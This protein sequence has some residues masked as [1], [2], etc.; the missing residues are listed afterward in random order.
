MK[1]NIKSPFLVFQDFISPLH[2]EDIIDDLDITIPNEDVDG[3]PLKMVMHHDR[4]EKEIYT[5]F[6][7]V[8]PTIEKHYNVNHRATTEI[9][10]EWYPQGYKQSNPICENSTLITRGNKRGWARVRDR[11]LT[12]ILFLTEYCD[13]PDFDS[14]YEVF[15][16][17]VEFVTWG[18]GF[19]AERGTLIVF[20]S[21]SNFIN[22]ISEVFVGDLVMA[23]FHMATQIPFIFNPD[24]YK[25]TYKEWFS[26]IA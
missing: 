3:N 20:P 4:L 22:V 19:N 17:K 15:G 26:H 18:F 16:G 24:E 12:A 13:K 11:D 7:G 6:L 25:G 14:L 9:D 23:K 5:R 10:F 8:A 21:T 1:T 2:C